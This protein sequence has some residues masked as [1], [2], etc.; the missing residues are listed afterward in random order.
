VLLRQ[1]TAM[2]TRLRRMMSTLAVIVGAGHVTPAVVIRAKAGIQQRDLSGKNGVP[3][4]RF[5]GD[6]KFIWRVS[7]TFALARLYHSRAFSCPAP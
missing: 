5:R 4:P 7:L 6:Y 1:L 2:H 3:V